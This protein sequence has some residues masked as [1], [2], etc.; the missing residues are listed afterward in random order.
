MGAFFLL[1]KRKPRLGLLKKL[2]RIAPGLNLI[3]SNNYAGLKPIL[4]AVLRRAVY[5][6]QRRHLLLYMQEKLRLNLEM[7]LKNQ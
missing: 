5:L 1:L 7:Y 3:L 6:A 2:Y 4:V